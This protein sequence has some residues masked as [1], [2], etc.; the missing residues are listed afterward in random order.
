MLKMEKKT[1]VKFNVLAIFC[2]VIFCMAITP[3]TF[4]NDTYY[5]IAIGKHIV[6][7]GTI[8]MMDPFSWHEDLPYTYPH[9]AYDVGTYLVYNLGESVGIGGFAALYIATMI[10]SVILGIVIY[11]ACCKFSKNNLISFFITLGIVYLLKNFIAARA[12]LVTYI[13]FA[14]TVLFIENFIETKKKRYAVYLIIIPIIIANVHCAVWPFYFVLYLPY[15]A[16]YLLAVI[17]DANIYYNVK[18]FFSRS[19][20]KRLSKK[21]GK[22]DKIEALNNKIKEL[23]ASKE[24]VKA[25]EEKRRANPYKVIFKKE[26]AVK[27]LILIMIISL[28]TG[29]LTPLGDVPYTYYIKTM[30]G[31]TT[32]N[33]SEHQPLTLI[34]NTAILI[35]FTM[36]LLVLIFTD[37]KLR[38]RDFFMLA[39]LTLMT[40]MSRRQASLFAIIAGFIFVKLITAL[41]EKYDKTGTETVMKFMTKL[42]GK[43]LTIFM[44]ILI[45]LYI[46]VP[47]IGNQFVNKASYPVDAANFIIENLDLD[48]IRLYNEYNYGSYLLYRGIPVFIDSRADLYAPEFNGTKGED[49]KYKGRNIFSD[50]INTSNISTYY[51]NTF[52]K[53][54]I[55]HTITTKKAKLNMFLSR[56]ENYK[57]IYSDKYFVIYERLNVNN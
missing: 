1:K 10:L 22:Q 48:E 13:L 41:F 20:L 15:I 30:Q 53:Y 27:W 32:Q 18:L 56:D 7:T 51:E 12:Q 43:I 57:E 52:N 25:I 37:T 55:T 2:I 26:P 47:K 44:G 21:E 23:E 11:Y 38:L 14:L 31:N 33:I 50:Y 5:S 35:V 36:F 6:E 19:K 8:D 3:I 16:E 54:D 42:P 24:N 46:F 9:W 45:S 29:L 4:Q 39:G 28:F 40:L 49:G 34:N 17:V